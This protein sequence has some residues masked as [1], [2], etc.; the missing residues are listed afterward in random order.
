MEEGVIFVLCH[1]GRQNDTNNSG[2]TLM[3]GSNLV[4]PVYQDLAILY[5]ELLNQP[6]LVG[7]KEV[8][9]VSPFTH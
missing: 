4:D 9:H 3:C 7:L 1:P 5:K 6:S 8:V 2:D